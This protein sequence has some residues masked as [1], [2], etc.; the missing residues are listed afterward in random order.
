MAPGLWLFLVV[1][2]LLTAGLT[3][4]P[5]RP[6]PPAWRTRLWPLGRFLTVLPT[7]RSGAWS[8]Q[9][10]ALAPGSP[11]CCA[12]RLGA[13]SGDG[14]PR[15]GWAAPEAEVRNRMLLPAGS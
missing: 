6:P 1:A 11:P 9:G 13:W 2:G 14:T 12:H 7:R 5:S 15:R 10:C 8:P 4:T 3:G